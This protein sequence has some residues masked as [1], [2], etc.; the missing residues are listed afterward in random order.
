MA[1]TIPA[2]MTDIQRVTAMV[3]AM[4][5]PLFITTEHVPQTVVPAV[6][7]QFLAAQTTKIEKTE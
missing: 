4:I 5:V 2:T 3:V 1:V 7:A 6:K